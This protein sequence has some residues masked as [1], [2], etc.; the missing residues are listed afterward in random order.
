MTVVTSETVGMLRH[1]VKRISFF[2]CSPA[3][4][5]VKEAIFVKFRRR[6]SPRILQMRRRNAEYN[7]VH[8]VLLFIYQQ[9]SHVKH[10]AV[11]NVKV[12]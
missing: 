1:T 9:L 4:L 12:K 3:I 8:S 5:S 7:K 2:V 11:Y 6:P 10:D